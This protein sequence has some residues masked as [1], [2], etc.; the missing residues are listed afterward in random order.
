MNSITILEN[1]KKHFRIYADALE[2][3]NQID[4]AQKYDADTWSLAQMYEH[5]CG[6][7]K[8][9]F[10]ANT[11]RCLEQRKG[12]I[13]GEKSDYGI[14]LFNA[15]SF[16]NIKI[17]MPASINAPELVGREIAVY[18]TEIQEVLDSASKLANALVNDKREYKT[19][20][21]AFGFLDGVEWFQMLEMHVR[22]HLTQKA[23]LES[24]C[25]IS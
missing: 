25:A 15:G 16:P 3:Y 12:Q 23:E 21:P 11:L 19:G 14:K 13:G 1:V 2:K 17:K 18:K 9:F 6:S 4:F 24:F 22:H 7:S 5:I 20:H 10:M 8:V